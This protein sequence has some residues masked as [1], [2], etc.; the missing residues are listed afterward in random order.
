MPL[1][2]Q[3]N[4]ASDDPLAIQFRDKFF[5]GKEIVRVNRR[6]FG[7]NPVGMCYSNVRNKVAKAGG[8]PLLGWL[9]S[10]FPNRYVEA[11]HHAVWINSDGEMVDVTGPAYPSMLGNWISFI[12]D[13]APLDDDA[14][15]MLPPVF[16]QLDN[17]KATSAYIEATRKLQ[18]KAGKF[19]DY[20]RKNMTQIVLPNGQI[21]Y[22][23]GD[24]SIIVKARS[25]SMRKGLREL[26]EGREAL[27]HALSAVK[28]KLR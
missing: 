23:S 21:A 2:P 28:K 19:Q 4:I 9:L 15:P 17:D 12:P 6:R 22:S 3:N 26:E 27:A 14:D 13:D 18:E 10:V 7:K 11:V 5:P 25:T 1:P 8:K 20:C 24:S 16:L